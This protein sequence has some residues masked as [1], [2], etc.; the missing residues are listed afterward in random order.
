MEVTGV[1]EAISEKDVTTKFGPKKTFG[2]RMDGQWY[3]CGFKRTACNKGDSVK[4]VY[5][6]DAYGNKVD[7]VSV[8]SAGVATGGGSAPHRSFSRGVFPIPKDDGQRSIIRQSCC[9]VAVEALGHT[10]L[11]GAENT[12]EE[13]AARIVSIASMLERYCTGELS[14]D[15]P[16]SE[17]DEPAF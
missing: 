6:P 3:N 8:T 10:L 5:H 13:V 16:D 17:E 9:K 15:T 7:S 11:P 14:S 2:L 12:P 4:V 1:V